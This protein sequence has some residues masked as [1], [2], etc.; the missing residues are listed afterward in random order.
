LVGVQVGYTIADVVAKAV[1]GVLI[2]MIAVQK[3]EAEDPRFGT[4]ARV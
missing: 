3:S 4:M 1:F 2:Y